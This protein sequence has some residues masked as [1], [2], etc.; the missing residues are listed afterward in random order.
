MRIG[1]EAQRIFRAKKHGMDIY[2]LKLIQELMRMDQVNDYFIFVAPGPDKCL[3]SK[4]N[5][6][7]IE[8]GGLTYADWEQISLP[9]AI[10]KYELD[11]LHCT[12]NTAP[13]R[14]KVPLITTV[15]DIIYLDQA[16]SGGST[17]QMLGHYYRKWIV[18]LIMKKSQ[19]VLTVSKYEKG[20][21]QKR[22]P[23]VDNLQYV[24]NGVTHTGDH[25]ETE[26]QHFR[27]NYDLP[28][29]LILFH[30]NLAPKKNLKNVLKAFDKFIIGNTENSV[31]L[32][33]TE[34]SQ[35]ELH[36][37]L[38]GL[39]LTRLEHKIH[40]TGYIPNGQINFLYQAADLFLYP[41]LRESFG[42]PIIESMS[43]GTP[44]ITSNV[45]AMPEVGGDAAVYVDPTNCDE[46]A[47]K[48]K[49]VI[50]NNFLSL[51]LGKM[52][53]NRAKDFSWANCASRTFR[54]YERMG[55]SQRQVHLNQ[56]SKGSYH[57]SKSSI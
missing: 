40:L 54:F 11:F 41:S 36:E 55:S 5:F 44:V 22:F 19:L 42:I 8:V 15:H 51:K 52:G 12:S 16:F 17:Y 21:M 34:I 18:P 1:I 28:E 57:L 23:D 2:V 45:T 30:G 50:S 26:I 43:V 31:K 24:Y 35:K 48:I 13:L 33:M 25:S 4:D 32:V 7:I 38:K 39:G 53:R 14:S 56:I 20:I 27:E 37:V 3:K 10:R 29:K 9:R 6:N 47:E 49:D 46:I